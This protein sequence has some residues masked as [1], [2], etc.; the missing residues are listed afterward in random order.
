[1]YSK[2]GISMQMR[3]SNPTN[4]YIWIGIH[5]GPFAYPCRLTEPNAIA[6]LTI[7]LFYGIYLLI[8]WIVNLFPRLVNELAATD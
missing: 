7:F 5:T 4:K 3:K 2:S 6:Q 8:N 1:M